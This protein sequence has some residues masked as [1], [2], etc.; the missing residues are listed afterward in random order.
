V[1]DW[2][3]VRLNDEGIHTA[4][5]SFVSDEG[6]TI[7]KVVGSDRHQLGLQDLGNL[8]GKRLMRSS[9]CDD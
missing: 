4:N 3:W 9:G 6:F 8:L 7:G 2:G 1:V 5:A